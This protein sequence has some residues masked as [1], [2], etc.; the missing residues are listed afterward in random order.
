MNTQT[1]QQQ[2]LARLRLPE[3]DL[4]QLSFCKSASPKSV[5]QWVDALPLTRTSFVSAVLYSALP[6][7][8]RLKT[9]GDNHVAVLEVVRPAVQGCIVGLSKAFLNQPIILPE[10]ARKA[11]TVAQALQKHLSNA[12][13]AAVRDVLSGRCSDELKALTIHRAITGLG[14]L[15]LRSYQLYTPTINQLWRELHTLYHLA[16]LH[17]LT[18]VAV[19]DPLPYHR[20]V[21][22]IDA[23]YLRICLLASC[24]PNQLRQ[25]DLYHIYLA[26]ET[27]A[28]KARLDTL[29]PEQAS[30]LYSVMLDSDTPP[31]YRT[32]LSLYESDVVRQI[33]TTAL[34]DELASIL[35]SPDTLKNMKLSSA[36]VTHAINAWQKPAQRSFDR[37]AGEGQLEVTV[38]LSNLHFHVADET[39]FNMFVRQPS[40]LGLDD[41]D[42]GIFKKR[43]LKL[44]D[45]IS[46][47]A[48]DPWGEA[49]DVA[50]PTITNS[51]A[52]TSNVEESI[53]RSARLRYRGQHP[54]YSVDVVDVSA[55]G[56]CLEW[57]T[58]SP[59]QLKAG[60]LLGVRE[61]GRHKWAIAAVRWVQQARGSSQLGIQ[62]L[63]PQAQPAAA[64]LLQKTG[65]SA[66]YLRVLALPAQRLANRPASLL[67]NALSFHEQ[68]K[69]KLYQNG[70][71]TT[72][73]LTRRLFTTGTVS[74]FAYKTLVSTDANTEK[75]DKRSTDDFE[76]VWR[77]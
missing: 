49:F 57:H 13:L 37:H 15:L 8:A 40:D 41:S 1:E 47:E 62:L 66:E 55:G 39:P 63:A 10:P 64:A 22:T 46:P 21:R 14:L 17:N 67:T 12:Y 2:L 4:K 19:D 59:L 16:E 51:S 29:D 26:L 61:P 31:V 18:R 44:K 69:I 71:L 35:H 77:E 32:R 42:D 27:L 53:R 56:Y 5:E 11:A 30:N 28:G 23:A 25:N 60:E 3:A 74:Q 48:A 68:Q 54:I 33:D 36:L 7:L 43:S 52:S 70:K 6:E 76:S 34:C 24:R 50:K 38:G 9:D 58:E 72:M 65:D 75:A 20:G 73:Q 45:R